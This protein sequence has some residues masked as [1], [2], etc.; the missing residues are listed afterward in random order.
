MHAREEFGVDPDDL[1]SPLLAAGASF[2]AFAVGAL[3]PVLPYLLGLSCRPAMVLT[4]VAL[5][6]CG[7]VVTQLTNRHWLF[8]G[9]P[10]ASAGCRRG[11]LTYGFG[12][13][14]GGPGL[15]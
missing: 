15:G 3:L 14:V 8:G 12:S 9:V 10:P 5:F 4:L 6:V 13:L 1:A 11:R 7:A 2:F